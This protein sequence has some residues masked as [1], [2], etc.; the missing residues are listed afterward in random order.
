MIQRFILYV[1]VINIA[2]NI[3]G[4]VI[5]SDSY[6]RLSGIIIITARTPSMMSHAYPAQTVCLSSVTGHQ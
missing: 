6:Y 4:D 2:L 5:S 3:I 1:N